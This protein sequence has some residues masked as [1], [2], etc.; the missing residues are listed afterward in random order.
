MNIPNKKVRLLIL[1]L[2]LLTFLGTTIYVV[3]TK[4]NNKLVGK[5]LE[6][7]Y[8]DELYDTDNDYD[9]YYEDE[10]EDDYYDEF[11]D[12]ELDKN[13]YEVTS[14][15]GYIQL[16]PYVKGL[17]DDFK[18]SNLTEEEKMRLVMASLKS[19]NTNTSQPVTDVIEKTIT[20]N[21]KVYSN[22]TPNIRYKSYEV[23]M[24]YSEI[25][26]SS[27]NFDY[28]ALMY[29]GDNIIYKYHESANGYIK[30]I[31]ENKD[32]IMPDKP[33]LVKAERKNKK[34][35]LY[36]KSG[37]K[38]EVYIFEQKEGYSYTYKFIERKS[39]QSKNSL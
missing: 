17:K 34:I 12:G 16:Y 4:D 15:Y 35:E 2:I 32:E 6:D 29:D 20:V 7:I 5:N 1:G 38:T 9:N 10:Y 8:Y 18:V 30:Y 36:L 23:T 28:S 31:A 14:L 3:I 39:E 25:F 11:S 27:V 13:S 19:K 22:T 26:G 21:G 33:I 24:M 37:T